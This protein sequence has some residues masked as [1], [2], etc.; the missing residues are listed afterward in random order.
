MLSYVVDETG[1]PRGKTTSLA[2]ATAT[3]QHVYTR[4]RTRAAAVTSKCFTTGLSRLGCP[5]VVFIC[6]DQVLTAHM[7]GG[8]GAI[9]VSKVQFACAKFTRVYT[10]KYTPSM[11]FCACERKYTLE[12]IYIRVN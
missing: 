9:Q 11:Y 7:A 10:C 3:L 4:V 6:I 5:F 12:L 8:G 2:W 1:E